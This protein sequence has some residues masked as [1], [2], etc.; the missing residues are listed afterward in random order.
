MPTPEPE[1]IAEIA[2]ARQMFVALTCW[3]CGRTAEWF[4]ERLERR[5][6]RY[7]GLT[8]PQLKQRSRCRECGEPGQITRAWLGVSR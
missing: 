6:S 3:R 1:E 2:R 7:P 4:G 5:F 8:L